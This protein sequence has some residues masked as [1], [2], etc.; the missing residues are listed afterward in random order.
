MSLIILEEISAP[1]RMARLVGDG[2]VNYG[3]SDYITVNISRN[4]FHPHDSELRVYDKFRGRKY[5]WQKNFGLEPL[6]I[7]HANAVEEFAGSL[8]A[9]LELTP[10]EMRDT[11]AQVDQV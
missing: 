7:E 1:I 4:T 5:F 6:P 10:S 3:D 11:L 2:S 8:G 9:D